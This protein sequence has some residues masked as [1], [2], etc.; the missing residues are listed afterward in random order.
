MSAVIA[1]GVS[2]SRTGK[3][4]AG[5]E[6]A[7]PSI[8]LLHDAGSVLAPQHNWQG[9]LA[10]LLASNGIAIDDNLADDGQVSSNPAAT[11]PHSGSFASAQD[12]A[13][14]PGHPARKPAAAPN[15][16]PQRDRDLP[17]NTARLSP[18]AAPQPGAPPPATARSRTN[19][20]SSVGRSITNPSKP[21]SQQSGTSIVSG[22]AHAILAIAGSKI[23]PISNFP[24]A[25][26]LPLPSILPLAP[27]VDFTPQISNGAPQGF[28]NSLQFLP[29]AVPSAPECHQAVPAEF[30]VLTSGNAVDRQPPQPLNLAERVVLPRAPGPDHPSAPIRSQNA[31]E[32]QTPPPIHPSEAHLPEQSGPPRDDASP[33]IAFRPEAHP[34]EQSFQPNDNKP[35]VALASGI[36]MPPVPRVPASVQPES[37][38]LAVSPLTLSHRAN[39]NTAASTIS[40]AAS[41]P[42]RPS[43]TLLDPNAPAQ[44]RASAPSADGAN[45][46][47]EIAPTP[48][49]T[50]RSEPFAS[51]PAVAPIFH[52]NSLPHAFA[53]TPPPWPASIAE[54]SSSLPAPAR[55][56]HE[57]FTAI[58]A[59]PTHAP[60]TWTLTGAHR[61]EA[62][63][64]DPSLGWVA[65]RAQGSAADAI[66]ATVVPATA[67]AAQV[68]GT[69]L[70]GLNAYMAHESPHLGPIA[71]S[72]PDS[73]AGQALTD[74][75]SQAQHDQQEQQSSASAETQTY[76][77]PERANASTTHDEFLNTSAAFSPAEHQVSVF[78]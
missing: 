77:A 32:I 75:Q 67:E 44:A 27:Q 45:L 64:Q 13:T 57:P 37:P 28:A 56:L 66:H 1:I 17:L 10:R 65:V 74:G 48:K 12:Q 73:T 68:L 19:T 7:V 25:S 61:A 41:L 22:S 3:P 2:G 18:K 62:G 4:P 70:A 46:R 49:I 76:I 9:T 55:L 43:H 69:H 42:D 31:F 47:L 63:F 14:A 53:F 26:D 24:P 36:S 5:I 35:S 33:A 21:A 71:L 11:L 72:A 54:P 8:A 23:P 30:S 78:V 51:S 16:L 40:D 6:A 52:E 29:P 60:A 39:S 15:H 58:D 59:G 38:D 50:H 20:E 34:P